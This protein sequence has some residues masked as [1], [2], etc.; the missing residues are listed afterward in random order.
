MLKSTDAKRNKNK[1]NTTKVEVNLPSCIQIDLVQGNELRH[2]EIFFSVAS[3]SLSTAASFWT[4]YAID[5]N[6]TILFSAIAFSGLTVLTVGIAIF[7]RSK[8]YQRK[9]KKFAPLD[10][11]RTI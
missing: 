3:L 7:Y 1:K 10:T 2:Y 5:Q 9:I 4:A 11:F 8:I 6:N